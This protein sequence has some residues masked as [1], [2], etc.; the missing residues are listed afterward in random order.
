MEEVLEEHYQLRP[1]FMLGGC[2]VDLHDCSGHPVNNLKYVFTFV[3]VF[4]RLLKRKT[5]VSRIDANFT[6]KE[7]YSEF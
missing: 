7:F 3:K 4:Y 2:F 6:L 1:E 5:N